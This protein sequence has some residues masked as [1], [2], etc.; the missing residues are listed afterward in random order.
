MGMNHMSVHL[1]HNKIVA[2]LTATGQPSVG[3]RWRIYGGSSAA[4]TVWLRSIDGHC[5]CKLSID[6]LELL[7]DQRRIALFDHDPATDR[8][9]KGRTS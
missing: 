3:I 7:Q 1:L 8:L 9:I 2:L 5:Q 6:E 4:G